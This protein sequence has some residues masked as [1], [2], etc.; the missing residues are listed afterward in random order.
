MGPVSGDFT[1]TMDELRVVARFAAYSAETVLPDFEA[2]LPNDPRPRAA[3]TFANGAPR[4]NLQRT[5]A[6][7]AHRASKEATSLRIGA[8]SF[9]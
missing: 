9:A 3:L 7:A 1:L 5:T 8:Q 6:F 4:T 2:E